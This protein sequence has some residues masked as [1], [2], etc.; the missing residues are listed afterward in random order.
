MNVADTTLAHLDA[1][2]LLLRMGRK[3][4]ARL[5]AEAFRRAWPEKVLP[6]YLRRRLDATLPASKQNTTVW[7]PAEVR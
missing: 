4:E 2:E 3:G 6:D 5:E 7:V 1:A